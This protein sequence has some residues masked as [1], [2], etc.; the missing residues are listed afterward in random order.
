MGRR[1]SALNMFAK[2]SVARAVD[3]ELVA[4]AEVGD[5]VLA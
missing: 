5:V 2:R 4:V 3:D 1:H